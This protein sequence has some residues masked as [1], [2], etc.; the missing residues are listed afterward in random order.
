MSNLALVTGGIR[1]IGAA[2]AIDLKK[3]GYNVCVSYKSNK[4]KA[5]EFTKTNNIPSF[6]FDVGNF[7]ECQESISKIKQNF[8]QSIGILINNAGITRDVMFHKMT[9]EQW[10]SVVDT[11]LNSLFN[12]CSCV[13]NDMRQQNFGR[14][15]N[16]S[17]VN[18]FKGQL[19]QTNYS[20]SK[21]GMLG[22]TKSLALESAACGITVNI[23]APGYIETDMTNKIDENIIAKIKE[24]IPMKRFGN[25]DEISKAILFLLEESSSYLTGTTIHINGGH[26]SG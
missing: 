24:Q 9:L 12:T 5:D 10:K 25:T 6:C 23:V 2:I 13:I 17:S 26:Y 11:N 16:I 4:E 18:A 8:N 3:K 19:G 21:S 20:A 1:G 15:I 22:F 7:D 14:I